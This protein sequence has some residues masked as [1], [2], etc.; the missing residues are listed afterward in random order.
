M[1]YEE[2]R[3]GGPP[4]DGIPPLDA[5]K[6]V[7]VGEAQGWL[8]K[9]EPA[10]VLELNGDARAY[11]LQVLIWHEIVNDIVGGVPVAVTFCPLCNTAI[12]FDRR[13]EGRV[14]DFGTTGNLRWSDLIMW[15]RQTES[16][17][18]Q[19]TGEA[20]VGELAGKKLALFPASIVSWADFKKAHR[21]GKVLS[22][23]TGFSRPYGT[24]PYVGYDEADVPPFLYEGPTD[25]R[26]LP[27]ERVVTVVLDKLAIAFPFSV[28][29]KE[30]AI[31]YR[32]DGHELVVFFASGA[33][34]AL[35]RELISESRSIGAA[36]V[37]APRVDQQQLTFRAE[38]DGFRDAETGSVWNVLGQAL[39]GP[40]V[41]K[42]LPSLVHG[43]HFWFSW[44]VF[45][46]DT[47]IYGA[48]K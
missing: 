5:P 27:K 36:S 9:Q 16:W 35:D 17:W 29:E 46:P 44:A 26:L 25:G 1:P 28:L 3:S 33:K 21:D 48:R 39:E 14:Y 45:R 38:G 12:V 11:P 40:L 41:G 13:L 6:F 23:E 8:D 20:I 4:R 42:R 22:R 30:R 2:I 19:V 34:S 47:V 10:I 37:F 31:N 32:Q 43:D 24:N 7:G 15:D 18:Q